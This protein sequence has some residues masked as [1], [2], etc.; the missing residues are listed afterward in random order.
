MPVHAATP[1]GCRPP[2]RRPRARLRPRLTF[3]AAA[4][5]DAAPVGAAAT[6][7]AAGAAGGTAAA[8]A[9]PAAPPPAAVLP[10]AGP[11]TLTLA[12]VGDLHMSPLEMGAFEEAR[13]QLTS[14]L[15]GPDGAPLPGGRVVQLGDLGDYASKPGSRACFDHAAAFLRCVA[16]ARGH[17][18]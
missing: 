15:C 14:A 5:T 3:A 7:A 6:A 8:S 11:D 10:P 1:A 4:A 12:V 9:D 16:R 18:L 17:A 13:R 2:Q